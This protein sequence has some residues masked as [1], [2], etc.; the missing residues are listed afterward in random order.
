MPGVKNKPAVLGG[1]PAFSDVFQ[2]AQPTIPELSEISTEL[3][4]IFSTKNITNGRYVHE[5]EK[6]IAKYLGVKHA[7]AVSCCTSGLILTCKSL[8]LTG[9]VIVPSFTFS[10]TVQALVWNNLKPVFVDCDPKNFN[11]NAKLIEDLITPRTSAIMAVHVFGMPADIDALVKITKKHGL[12]LIFDSAHA[13]GA[14]YDGKLVGGFGDAEVFS[15][16]PTKVLTS[17]E[18]GIVATNDDA[19]AKNIRIGRD[20]AN[21]GD[22]NCQFAGLNARMAEFNAILGLKGLETMEEKV[23]SRNRLAEVYKKNLKNVPGISFQEGTPGSRSTYK[24]LSILVEPE[25]FGLSRK[26]LAE[27]LDKENIRTK[28][29]Y[30]PPIHRQKFITSL[31]KVDENK[32]KVTNHVSENILSLPMFTHMEEKDIITICNAAKNIRAHSSEIQVLLQSLV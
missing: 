17:G 4:E 29:Y 22:Y 6:E 16:S 10:A 18:G 20:Y 1:K 30:Y 9:E 5:F 28:K 25:L 11:I 14:K 27:C 21:P 7:V 13:I 15:L 3:K 8:E 26:I 2:F 19:L 31:F 23:I 12:K 32:L 24:D